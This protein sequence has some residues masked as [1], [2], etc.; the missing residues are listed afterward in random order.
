[1]KKADVQSKIEEVGIIPAIRTSSARDARFAAETVSKAGIPIVEITMTVPGAI[2]LISDIFEHAP[3]VIVGAGTVLDIETARAC[4]RAGAHFLTSPGL[5]LDIVKFAHLENVLMI[6]G[7][8]TPTEVNAAWKGGSDMVK[9]FP[10]SQVGGDTYIKAL[11]GPF[12]QTPLIAAGGVNQQTASAFITAGATAL[13]I[14][15]ELIPRAAIE[16][17]QPER[18]RELA[19]R[20]LNLVRTS[21]TQLNLWKAP[22][23]RSVS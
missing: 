15:S 18:I 8:L 16:L 2:D 1:M 21:R 4:L 9:I 17:H 10:C 22:G 5:D 6:A 19:R 12:P 3:E 14:G 13:G 11:R 7:A 20:F 23:L